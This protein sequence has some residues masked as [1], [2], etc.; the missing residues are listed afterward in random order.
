MKKYFLNDFT[1]NYYF[2]RIGNAFN[3]MCIKYDPLVVNSVR[4]KIKTKLLN[5]SKFSLVFQRI[6]IGFTQNLK[7]P[8]IWR[9]KIRFFLLSLN[10]CNFFV[11]HPLQSSSIALKSTARETFENEVSFC[12]APAGVGDRIS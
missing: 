3:I 8:L 2:S 6:P 9:R 7:I 1:K 11:R 4:E 5:F 12:L 10:S